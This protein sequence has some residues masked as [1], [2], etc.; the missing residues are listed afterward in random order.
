MSE[1]LAKSGTTRAVFHFFQLAAARLVH[2]LPNL[3]RK[4]AQC[5]RTTSCNL[6]KQDSEE[7]FRKDVSLQLRM[8]LLKRCD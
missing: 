2:I 7:A 6:A 1:A 4:I 5:N 8:M 3:N